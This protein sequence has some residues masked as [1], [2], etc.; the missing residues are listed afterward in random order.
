MVCHVT[1]LESI[2]NHYPVHLIHLPGSNP[3]L[4]KAKYSQTV[5]GRL[6]ETISRPV[7]AEV[8]YYP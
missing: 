5:Q 3:C 7:L 1:L 2:I 6:R 8:F 4:A